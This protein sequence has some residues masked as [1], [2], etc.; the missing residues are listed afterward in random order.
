MESIE[1]LGALYLGKLVNPTQEKL[2]DQFLFYDSKNLTTHA[3]CVGMTGSGKTGLGIAILEEAALD[4]IPAIIIDPKG[5]LGN[6]LLTFPS[7]SAQEFLPWIDPAE[8]ERKGVDLDD[9]ANIVANTWREGLAQSDQG[10]DRIKKF[11]NS[12]DV[13]IYTPA[14]QAGVP[15]SILS[16]FAAPSQEMMLDTGAIRERILSLTSSLLGLLGINADPIKSQEHIL[17]STII[18]QS[19]EKGSD[20][21]IADLIQQVQRP[22]FSKIGV[23][24][25]DTFFSQKERMALSITLNNLLASPGFQAWMEGE[26]L[27]VGQLLY[28]QEGKNKLSV[29]SIAHLS[30]AERMFFVTLLLNEIISWMRKQPGTSS[31]RALLY[32]D[33]IFG[34]FPPTSMPPSK[35]PMLTLL[36]QARAFGL[37][38]FLAT[39]NPV[40]LDYKGLANCGTWFI[41]KLQTERDKARVLEGLAAA[42]NGEFQTKDLDKMLAL[43]GNHTFIMRSIYQKEPCIFQTRWT[44]SYLRGPL[45]LAQIALL[46]KKIDK[47]FYESATTK[48]QGK[49]V[50]SK[51]LVPLGIPE[52]FLSQS[53]RQI[54]IY[55][56]AQVI[57]LAKLHFLDSKNQIDEW[58]EICRISPLNENGEKVD[59][60]KGDMNL[61]IKAQLK[62]LPENECRFD[63][64][65]SGLMQKRHYVDFEKDFAAYLYQNQTLT[66]YRATLLNLSSKVGEGEEEFRS[67]ID[68][69]IREKRDELRE[70]VQ[71]SY[72]VKLSALNERLR[73]SEE[74]V[75]LQ[76]KQ[77][78]FR[79]IETIL[80]FG[81]AIL[82][83]VLGK[84]VTKG[85]VS[86]TSTS[87][88]KFGRMTKDN[89][90]ASQAQENS[91][92]I[93]QQMKDLK[94]QMEQEIE[95]AIREKVENVTIDTIQIRPR[96]SDIVVENISVV[97]CGSSSRNGL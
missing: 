16:S 1:K 22:L 21:T 25:V 23:M 26:P 48:T 70:K 57:G 75:D 10:L 74:K 11:K 47:K 13:V 31:L 37:G 17:I 3:V 42:S 12:A 72:L 65:P 33:E 97:W 24:D 43:T 4:K 5:D 96:K 34:Y 73:R 7:L 79:I 40:D 87:M 93:Q 92:A 69:T 56:K 91:N 77:I 8:A 86:Q 85:T 76:K 68:K 39:Q 63:E 55:Y 46:T 30:D 27:D 50:L 67:R 82:G 58:Q 20:L 83:A 35:L 64:L 89:Q 19:W 90:E 80:S 81:G 52:Y 38:V 45:T 95:R 78:G 60:E 66:L 29:I 14:S 61:E 15:L 71:A 18:N 59:W 2:T 88:R 84:G 32:M 49:L 62:N 28:T 44:L 9:Y 41:G 54:G 6:L 51:P 36:K 53:Q 94:A